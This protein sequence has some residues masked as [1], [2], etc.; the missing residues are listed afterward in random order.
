VK[1]RAI[2]VSL[3]SD[4]NETKIN[5]SCTLPD[6]TKLLVSLDYA[7]SLSDASVNAIDGVG[8]PVLRRIMD[9]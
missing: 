1:E 8:A 3:G 5:A 6:L 9:R 7:E 2:T 4:R